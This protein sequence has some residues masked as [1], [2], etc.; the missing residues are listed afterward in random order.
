MNCPGCD[1]E[2]IELN[3]DDQTVRKCGECG[4]LWIDV[5]DLNRTLLHHNLPGLETLGGKVNPDAMTGQCPD[6]QVDLVQV[7][8]GERSHP[9][10]YDSCESCGGVFLESEFLQVRDYAMA[11]REIIDFFTAFAGRLLRR[12]AVAHA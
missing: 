6:C 8:G 7:E 3:G 9:L 1:V 12:K 11:K 4:G 10:D 2:M 5:S